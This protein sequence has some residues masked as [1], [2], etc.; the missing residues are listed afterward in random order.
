MKARLVHTTTYRYPEPA[1][2][3]PHFIRLR[4][5]P[6]LRVHFADYQMR[7]GPGP[8]SVFWQ[9]DVFG[10]FIARCLFAEPV[11]EL[12]IDVGLTVWVEEANPFDFVVEP[13]AQQWPFAYSESERADLA[14]YLTPEPAGPLL[15]GFLAGISREFQETVGFLIALNQR[16]LSVVA[17]EQRYDPGTMEPEDTLAAGSGACRDSA[18]LLV[19]A[20]RH[21]GLGARFVSGYIVEF[22]EFGGRDHT[23]LHAWA[24]V[25]VPGAGWI[26]L[27]PST[28]LL[29]GHGHVPLAATRH[30]AEAAAVTGTASVPAAS[31]DYHMELVRDV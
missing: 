31:L 28:G 18:W 25:Y 15:N 16:V 11:D 19:Q 12:T 4:P 3:G 7:V 29:A 27:D 14:G 2:L 13:Q 21:L 26:G 30:W 17:H 23:G 6:H 5:S 10:N 22:A 1:F 8:S 9:Q 20:C 24:D